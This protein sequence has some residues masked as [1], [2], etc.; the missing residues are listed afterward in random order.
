M[1]PNTDSG[2]FFV[3]LAPIFEISKILPISGEVVFLSDEVVFQTK[4]PVTAKCTFDEVY[5]LTKCKT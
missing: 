4:S 2:S 3:L 1:M 5:L